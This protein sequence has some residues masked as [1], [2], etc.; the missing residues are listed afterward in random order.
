[1]IDLVEGRLW[2]KG[3]GFCDLNKKRMMKVIAI[4]AL[5]AGGRI[6][7]KLISQNTPSDRL[8]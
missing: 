6:Y 4:V 3:I 1:M 8:E 7:E 2:K 5:S